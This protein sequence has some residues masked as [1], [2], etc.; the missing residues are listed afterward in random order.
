MT[1]LRHLVRSSPLGPLARKVR[2]TAVALRPTTNSAF[3]WVKAG[4]GVSTRIYLYNYWSESYGIPRPR[5]RWTLHAADGRRVARGGLALEP[6]EL[7]VVDVDRLLTSSGIAMPFE[8][9]FVIRLSSR[10]L[11]RGMPLQLWGE[12]HSA[13]DA[14]SCVHGQ[15]G[16]FEPWRRRHPTGG[17]LV[18]HADDRYETF[19]VIQNCAAAGPPAVPDFVF[20]RGDGAA[21]R[22]AAAPIARHGFARYSIRELIP[23][24]AAFLGGAAGNASVRMEAPSI[25]TFHFH[26]HRDASLSVNHAAGDYATAVVPVSPVPGARLAPFGRGPLAVAVGWDDGAIRSEYVL[27]NNLWPVVPHAFDIRVNAAD[28]RTVAHGER[29]VLDSRET[30]VI[31]LADVLDAASAPRPFRG[32]VEVA[33]A[34]TDAECPSGFQLVTELWAG[35]R[36]AASDVGSD[37]FNVTP[38][39]TRIFARVLESAD[40]ETFLFLAYPAMDISMKAEAVVELTLIAADGRAQLQRS[41]TVSVHGM[42]FDSITN[43]FPE[44]REFLAAGGGTG[45]VKARSTQA[46]LFGYHIVRHKR[47]GTLACDHLIGG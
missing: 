29:I 5:M 23:D 35:D 26:R 16:Y 37:L 36:V 34:L 17:H 7:R 31:A 10:R 13:G 22:V 45:T 40:F 32:V 21:R 14:I 44:A 41:A 28:G 38:G 2:D 9:N 47:S 42:L 46:R 27:H 25:R 30:R 18:V 6:Q 24:G 15:W 12:Y 3:C 11:R 1:G 4:E 33:L 39:R 8:G 19:L 43:L 20:Y